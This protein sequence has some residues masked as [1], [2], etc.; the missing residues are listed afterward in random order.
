MLRISDVH[1]NAFYLRK[2]WTSELWHTA[3][4]LVYAA[5]RRNVCAGRYERWHTCTRLH[6]VISAYHNMSPHRYEDFLLALPRKFLRLPFRVAT[7]KSVRCYAISSWL[8]R[9]ASRRKCTSWVG[10]G[11]RL[12]RAAYWATSLIWTLH[13]QLDIQH[14]WDV[15]F[16]VGKC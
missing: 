5:Y 6:V 8:M 11:G 15:N 14:A 13:I 1:V 3:V 16:M 7:L 2:F 12:E 4:C 9:I 10:L